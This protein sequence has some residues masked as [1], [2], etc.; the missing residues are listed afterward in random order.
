MVAL[1]LPHASSQP[2]EY[3]LRAPAAK[4][5]QALISQSG[6]CS[7]QGYQCV[8]GLDE[9][10]KLLRCGRLAV[11]SH[12]LFM[13]LAASCGFLSALLRAKQSHSIPHLL[14]SASLSFSRA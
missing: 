7:Y 2:P 1:T 6:L 9:A 11:F 4:R 13:G 12:F 14:L 3:M 5:Q 10:G 8:G